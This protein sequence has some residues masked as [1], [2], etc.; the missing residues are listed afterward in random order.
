[1]SQR[2]RLP[3][4]L[5]Q[6]RTWLDLPDPGPTIASCAA[7]ATVPLDGEEAAWL[8]NVAAPSAGKRSRQPPRRSHQRPTQRDHRPSACSAGPAA[9]NHAQSPSS[10]ASPATPSSHSATCLACRRARPAL[11][12]RARGRTGT[13]IS[14]ECGP[15]STAGRGPRGARAQAIELATSIITE[16]RRVVRTTT[17]PSA[18]ADAIE[19]A[20]LVTCWGRAAVPRSGYGRREIEDV[21]TVEEPPRL[22]RQAHV[23]ARGLYA[24]GLDDDAV[25]K[26]MRRVALDSMP[27]A[28]LAVLRALA[29]A[30]GQTTTTVARAARLHRYVAGRHLEDMATVGVVDDLTEHDDKDHSWL[31]VGEE[32]D[33]IRKVVG[34]G[35]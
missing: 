15:G 26:M 7:A 8:L 5:A 13:D 3:E 4:L 35:D 30:E 9:R 34:A 24:L 22:I 12:M 19:D 1:M 33:L 2:N 6:L 32:G 20:V 27:A 16:A 25:D 28:R 23:L 14:S 21:P 29:V 31:L 10:P 11:A 18:V 17:V